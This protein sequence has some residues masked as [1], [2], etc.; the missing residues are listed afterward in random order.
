[1]STDNAACK[2]TDSTLKAWNKKKMH[3]G[4]MFC[5][6]AKAFDCVNRDILLLKLQH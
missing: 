3:V 1:M 5:D 6:L 2:L 4:G